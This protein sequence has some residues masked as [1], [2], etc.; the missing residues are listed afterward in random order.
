MSK[1]LQRFHVDD[2]LDL[3]WVALDSSLR[4]EVA[5]QLACRHPEGALLRVEFYAVVVEI[6]KG[7]SQVIE[8]AVCFCGFD[9]D[10]VNVNFDVMTYLLL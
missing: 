3:L 10:V 5:Q 8:Q 1:R 2:G 9:D 4:D 6:G 7:F